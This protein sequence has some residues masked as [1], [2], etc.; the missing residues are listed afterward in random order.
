MLNT[1]PN[2]R[3]CIVIISSADRGLRA[4][5]PSV[6]TVTMGLGSD[7]ISDSATL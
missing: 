1:A 3:V 4:K 5:D 2:D 6:V 7:S